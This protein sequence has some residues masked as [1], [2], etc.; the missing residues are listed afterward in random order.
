MLKLILLEGQVQTA[1]GFHFL[2]PRI[3]VGN[4]CGSFEIDLRGVLVTLISFVLLWK[5]VLQILIPLVLQ[6][7][8]D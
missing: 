1:L 8:R 3:F 2:P 5:T 4:G 6:I 7:L